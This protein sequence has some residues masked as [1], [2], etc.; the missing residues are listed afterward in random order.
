MKRLGHGE[1]RRN[2]RFKGSKRPR[3]DSVI[4]LS[5]CTVGNPGGLFRLDPVSVLDADDST[6]PNY[7]CSFLIG[8]AFLQVFGRTQGNVE[9]LCCDL[10]ALVTPTTRCGY[11]RRPPQLDL[12]AREAF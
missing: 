4:L 9:S 5:A 2:A 8:H 10:R 12:P 6:A 3:H 7:R 1:P 11:G